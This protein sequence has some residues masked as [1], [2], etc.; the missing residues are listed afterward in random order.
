MWS[1]WAYQNNKISKEHRRPSNNS[2]EAKQWT[3][4]D[5]HSKVKELLWMMK[6]I[7]VI[8]VYVDIKTQDIM[9]K[10]E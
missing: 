4:Q 3:G 2:N 9:D 5:Y 1:E 10:K 8:R 6:C 7:L